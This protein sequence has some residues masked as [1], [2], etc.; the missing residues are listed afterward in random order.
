MPQLETRILKTI[1][2][3]R[4][5]SG[6]HEEEAKAA[7]R[8][9]EEKSRLTELQ[10]SWEKLNRQ[11]F[12]RAEN[13][14]RRTRNLK[15]LGSYETMN[16][17]KNPKRFKRQSESGGSGA[18]AIIQL[19]GG[20][21][22]SLFGVAYTDDVRQVVKRIDAIDEGLKTDLNTVKTS[23]DSLSQQTKS[24]MKE[25]D[26]SIKMVMKMA[27]TVENKVRTFEYNGIILSRMKCQELKQKVL[28]IGQ[29]QDNG[30]RTACDRLLRTDFRDI[31]TDG[32]SS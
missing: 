23:Q 2:R 15:S 12:R 22:Q 6:R 13:M 21:L 19:T 24:T 20:V 5:L 10:E 8:T 16:K 27:K 11:L 18:D 25:Q 32:S 17:M 1:H 28:K 31:S 3:L 4:L 14:R 26:R 30:R 29:G 9:S 7:F